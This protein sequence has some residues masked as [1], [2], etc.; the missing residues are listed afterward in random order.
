MLL[1]LIN[2]ETGA[3]LGTAYAE[4]FNDRDLAHGEE[5]ARRH[6]AKEAAMWAHSYEPLR[7]ATLVVV[8]DGVQ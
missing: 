7:N 3:C 8:P 2:V 6:L 1:K 5:L 4:Q